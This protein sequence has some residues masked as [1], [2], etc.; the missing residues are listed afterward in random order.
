[1]TGR[2]ESWKE[3]AAHFGRRVRTVQR[4]EKEE[5]LPV[6]R[7]NHLT[8]AT[9]YAIPEELDRWW[10][11]RALEGERAKGEGRTA[12]GGE[13]TDNPGSGRT[14][15]RRPVVPVLV[16]AIAVA[17]AAGLALVA[18]R[19]AA[20]P[21]GPLSDE[22]APPRVLEA[23]YL[24]HRGSALEVER[25]L[26]LCSA[27]SA[28]AQGDR[29]ASRAEKASIHECLA[30]GALARV[31]MGRGSSSDGLL[32]ATREAEKS[33]ALD[34]RRADAAAIATWAAY[35]RDWNAGAAE[36]GYRRAIA[37]DPAAAIPHHG[38]AHLLSS[39]GRHDEAIAEL[40]RAQRAQPL[41]AALNDDGCWFYY[42][43]R[44]YEEAIDEADRAL[45][46]EPERVGALQCVLDARAA[47]GEHA[48]AREAAVTILRVLGDPAADA[49]AAA[50]PREAVARFDR[51]IIE[52]LDER[53]ASLARPA[54]PYALLYGEL[55]ERDRAIAWLER[56]FA[57]HDSVLLLVR[58]HP[59]FDSLRGD[60]RL[61]PLLRRAG[62]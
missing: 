53:R 17:V 62:V 54:T 18:A 56:A 9:V 2:L 59:A 14:R 23:R 57:D 35:I 46:L 60:P 40:R 52:R 49:I 28:R 20:S 48:Q 27:E 3:I 7:H 26:A 61:E 21:E 22:S 41:S 25:A 24:L 8:R 33:L 30:Q 13:E 47:R 37:L 5:G 50:P 42:R 45:R 15:V 29:A 55:G 1:M 32:E 4:W 36:S 19:R 16:I 34:P 39:R 31:R 6:H 51:R 12:K 44:R 58:V 43:A 11:S 10:Q 38:M